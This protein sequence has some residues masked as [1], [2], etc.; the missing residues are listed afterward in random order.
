[1]IAAVGE[2]VEDVGK[3]VAWLG[4]EPVAIHDDTFLFRSSMN[5]TF[6]SYCM[7]TPRFHA[8]K[9]K[10]VARAKVKRLSGEGLSR[11]EIPLPP[12]EEQDRVVAILDRFDALVNDLTV[13]LPAELAARRRQY[14]HY[15]DRLL[16]FAEATP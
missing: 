2:T 11:I 8:Q 12:R 15:R 4:D 6:V 13:E 10:H 5:P 7:Q 16:A 14:E 1:M 9:N 3:A